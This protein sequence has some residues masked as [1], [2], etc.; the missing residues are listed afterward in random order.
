MVERLQLVIV[1]LFTLVACQPLALTSTSV[2][3]A[4]SSSP[5]APTS[6]APE[7]IETET[8]GVTIGMWRLAG[9]EA[10]TTDG[11]VLAEHRTLPGEE[12]VG[13]LLTY[14]FVPRLESETVQIIG[15][16]RGNYAL[17]VLNAVVANPNQGIEVSQPTQFKWD[18]FDA[19]Y[20]LLS[21]GDGVRAIVLAIALPENNQLVVCNVSAPSMT[22]NEIRT[23]LPEIFQGMTINGET[24]GGEALHELPNPLPF[25][26]YNIVNNRRQPG[27]LTNTGTFTSDDTP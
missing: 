22:A 10:N 9:W 24:I 25:P 14:V 26:S 6:V 19:A 13:G 12:R 18:E 7:W 1:A 11:I 8:G 3:N 2:N 15:P 23:R 4:L 20:Y 16:A 27:A 5:Q 17:A 21:S